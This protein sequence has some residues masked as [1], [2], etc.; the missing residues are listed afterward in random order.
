MRVHPYVRDRESAS[1]VLNQRFL[2][3]QVSLQ[4]DLLYP[5]VRVIATAFALLALAAVLGVAL[6]LGA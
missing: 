1:Q 2:T 6:G 4:A 5:G 3:W